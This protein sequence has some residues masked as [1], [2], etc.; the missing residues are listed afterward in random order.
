MTSK[1]YMNNQGWITGP[2]EDNQLMKN[3]NL[4]EN[5]IR[6]TIQDKESNMLLSRK[7]KYLPCAYSV[8]KSFLS[9]PRIDCNKLEAGSFS[10]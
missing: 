3:M 7:Q 9:D 1:V 8:Q 5:K 2:L 10:I 6:E 4:K